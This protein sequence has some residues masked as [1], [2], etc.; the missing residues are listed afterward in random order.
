M[1]GVDVIWVGAGAGG[2]GGCD[3]QETTTSTTAA[4]APTPTPAAVRT[5]KRRGRPGGL[6]AGSEGRVRA[7]AGRDS[8]KR[9]A[10]EYWRMGSGVGALTT[11]VASSRSALT[12]AVFTGSPGLIS[13]VVASSPSV[14]APT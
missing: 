4:A 14:D 9:A 11:I 8:S 10:A 13:T 3:R 7:G 2:G 1:G 12:G 5:P 6:S